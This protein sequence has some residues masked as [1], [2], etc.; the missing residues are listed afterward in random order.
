MPRQTNQKPIKKDFREHLRDAFKHI[1]DVQWLGERSPLASP[2]FLGDLLSKDE[3][4]HVTMHERGQ[5]LSS[6][7]HRAAR[8]LL[9]YGEKGA[10]HYQLVDKSFFRQNL[11]RKQHKALCNLRE[12]VPQSKPK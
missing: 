9:N 1:G 5:V 7:L 3:Q 12:K 8:G 2:Y 4:T 11:S 10:Y 6:L